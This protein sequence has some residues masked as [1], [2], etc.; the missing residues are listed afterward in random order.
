M[1]AVLSAVLWDIDGTLVTS[2]GVIGRRFLDA[3]DTVCGVRPDPN[4]LDFGGRLDPEIAAMLVAEVDGHPDQAAEVLAE[5]ETLVATNQHSMREHVR[6]LP[7]VRE[8]VDALAAAGIPQTVVTGNVESVGRFKLEAAELV[9]PIDIELG[10]FGASGSDR[11][12]VAQSALDRLTGAGWTG[13]VESCWVVGDTPRDVAC[14]L[15]LGL[16][17]ALVATGRHTVEALSGLGAHL[18]LS[19]LTDSAALQTAWFG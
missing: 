8:M 2:G 7:G 1:K 4:G 14:A 12:A 19:E 3:V 10:G 6:V 9:P 16:S 11:T 17:C 18:V 15:P 5:Y 13:P